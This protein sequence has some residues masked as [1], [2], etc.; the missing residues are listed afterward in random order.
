MESDV[1]ESKNVALKRQMLVEFKQQI[2]D[3]L[4]MD[5]DQVM[6]E[7]VCNVASTAESVSDDLNGIDEE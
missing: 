6:W 7:H 5:A 1:A 4:E 2:I 3:M